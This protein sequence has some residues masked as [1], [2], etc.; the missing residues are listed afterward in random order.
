MGS[1]D[2]RA[3]RR[4]MLVAVAVA[5]AIA[6]AQAQ[7][8]TAPLPVPLPVP[9]VGGACGANAS[10]FITAG[11]ATAAQS[12]T[13]LNVNQ[14]SAN[15][16]LNWQSFNI[17]RG[18]T[19]NFRQP[20]AASIALNRIFQADASKIL[21]SLNANGRVFL[22]NQNGFVFGEGAQVNVGGLL[23]STLN[24]TP[25][26]VE[27]G[28]GRASSEGGRPAFEAFRDS[29]GNKLQS[30][31]VTIEAGAQINAAGGQVLVFAPE[32][33]N[34]GTIK[35]P[36]GQTML[37][38]GESIYLAE[39]SELRGLLVEIDTGDMASGIVTNGTA[40]NATG[41]DPA[42]LAG[43]IIAERGNITL[44]GLA[45]NQLGRVSATTSVRS[46][47]TI[48]LIAR[49]GGS[50]S[51]NAGGAPAQLL[52][53]TG[54]HLTLGAHS[55]T[56]VTLERNDA[57]RTVDVNAQPRSLVE[58]EGAAVNIL[59]AARVTATAGQIRATARTS[60]QLDPASFTN[61]SDGSRIYVAPGATLDVSGASVDL[62]V[63]RNVVRVELRGSQLANSPLQRDGALRSEPVF[64]DIRVTGTR[65]DGS[66]WRGTPLADVS[67]DISTIARTVQ[68][69]S[70][71][72]GGITLRSQGDVL[73]SAS[74]VF[75]V[76]GGRINFQDGFINTSQLLGVD[77]RV[78]DMSAADPSRQYVRVLNGVVVQHERWGVTQQFGVAPGRF[79]RGY[80]EGKDAGSVSIF[81]P[82][83]ALDGTLRAQTIAGVNQRSAP[84]AIPANELY[85]AF[86][87]RPLGGE[88]ILGNVDAQLSPATN[89]RDYVIPDVEVAAGAVLPQ[90]RSAAGGAFDP[91]VDPVMPFG[92]LRLRPEMLADGVSRVRVV[93]NGE[94]SLPAAT[95]LDLGIFGSLDV[96]AGSATI[97]GSIT[98]PAGSVRI[99]GQATAGSGDQLAPA[100]VVLAGSARIDVAGTWIN[101]N[102][103]LNPLAANAPVSINGGSISLSGTRIETAAGSVLN[104]DGGAWRRADGSLRYGNGG[105]LS[106]T[107]AG[108][109]DER[110]LTLDGTMSAFAFQRGGSLA[111]TTG[112]LCLSS[113]ACS[114]APDTA[115]RVSPEQ[116]TR[117]GF[118]NYS[119]TSTLED[120]FVEAGTHLAPRQH[121]LVFTSEV[122]GIATGTSLADFTTTELLPD[123]QRRATNLSLTAR[124]GTGF[125][126]DNQNID[127]AAELVLAAG[128]S[129]TT[130]PLAAVTLSSNARIRIDGLV[131]AP[132]GSI[133]VTLDPS[134][135]ITDFIG[136]QGIWLGE[137]A[138]L[139]ASGVPQV[140]INGLGLRTGQIMAGGQVSL[141]ANRG[142]LVMINGSVIDVSGTTGVLDLPVG[143][144]GSGRTQPETVA[145]GGGRIQLAA[146]EGIFANSTFRAASG[147]PGRIAGGTISVALSTENRGADPGGFNPLLPAGSR[148]IEISE[149]VAP[150]VVAYGS[151]PAAQLNGRALISAGALRDSGAD[152]LSFT[153][154]N[155]R[156]QSVTGS[157]VV[158]SE[159]RVVFN[160]D[161]Q[162]APRARLSFDAS[163][164]ESLG[165]TAQLS[166][167]Y[168]SLGNTDAF[169]QVL[170]SEPVA[171][172][173]VLDVQGGLVDVVGA[174]I[175]T[176]FARVNLTSRGD[177]R[178]RG[179]QGEQQASI[180]G[181]F[182]TSGAL[183]LAA[184]QVYPT[185]LSSFALEARGDGADLRGRIEIDR[186]AGDA[187]DVY[188]AGGRLALR[189]DDIVNRGTVRAPFGELT[190]DAE[191]LTLES[192]SVLSTSA[193]G[194]TI[195][196]GNTQGGFDWTYTLPNGQTLEFGADA[197]P[198]PTQRI[199]LDAEHI[200]F[201][202]GATVD[203]SGGGDLQAYEFVPGPTGTRDVL[204]NS[205]RPEQFA[206][207]PTASLAFAP[208]DAAESAFFSAL[209][210]DS[211]VIPEG[212]AG[213]PAGTYA[214]LPSR[215][216]LLP[217]AM[218]VTPV[219]GFQDLG[220]GQSMTRLDG[221]TV[222]AAYRSVAG[223][224]LRDA[225]TSG[226]A[227]SPASYARLEARYDLNRASQFFGQQIAAGTRLGFR[228]PA[229]AGRLTLTPRETLLLDGNLLTGGAGSN[230]RGA[231]VE[232]AADR[233]RIVD[234]MPTVATLGEVSVLAS[235][236][237]QL[238]PESLV[239]GGRVLAGGESPL[240]EVV[241]ST[242]SI[243]EGVRLSVPELTLAA[244][245]ALTVESGVELSTTGTTGAGEQTLRLQGDAALLRM[246]ASDSQLQLE[247]DG[248]AG[249]TGS[250]TIGEGAVVRTAGALRLD[251]SLDFALLGQLDVD[252]GSLALGAPRISLGEAPVGTGGLLLDA[253]QLASWDLDELELSSTSTL[254]F[255]SS[256][257]LA[258]DRLRLRTA[259]L[260]AV[261]EDVELSINTG[262]L[263][264]E[265]PNAAALDAPG[266]TGRLHVRAGGVELGEGTFSLGGF[267][268]AAFDVAGDI[269][270]LD[271]GGLNAGGALAINAQRLV[272]AN[273]VT[274]DFASAAHLSFAPAP[275]G[276]GFAPV[277]HDAGLGASFRM[278]GASVDLSSDILAPAGIVDV[279]AT[280]GAV[281]LS[282]G[283]DIDVSG[284]SVTFDGVT[285]AAP[286]GTVRLASRGGDVRIADGALVDVSAGGTADSRAGRIEL[287]AA[288][289]TVD[290][291]GD[292]AGAAQMAGRG[293]EFVVDANSILN[294]GALNSR[295]NAS[296]FD[297]LRDL[298]L[299]G[300]G[301]LILASGGSILAHDV[302]LAA[303]AGRID[304]GGVIDAR[305]AAGGSVN[306]FARDAVTVSG[307]IL[308]NATSDEGRGG[309]IVLGSNMDGVNL[310]ASSVLDV[311][312]GADAPDAAGDVNLRVSR[313]AL[314]RLLD[315]DATNDSTRLQGTIRGHRRLGLEGFQV[316]TDA[317]GR[318]LATDTTASPTN[319]MFND[320]TNFMNGAAQLTAALGR[321]GDESFA[322]LPGIEIR[323]AGDLTLT[324]DWNLN[325]WRFGGAP[326]VLTLRAGD[327]LRFDRSLSDGFDAITGGNAFNLTTTEDSWSY[328]LAA[329]A[330]HAAANPLGLL[331]V[332]ALAGRTGN[333]EIASGTVTS[334]TITPRM[335]RTGTGDIEI[336]VAGD[337]IFG[338]Q[339]SVLYTA[340]VAGEGIR[341][342][343]A[344][345]L[346][347]RAYPT[348]GGDISIDAR[349]DILG[350][351][352]NQ[353]V[354]DWLWR[355]GRSTDGL[356]PQATGWTVNFT[357]FAQGV[358]ALGGGD[359]SIRAGGDIDKLY[360]SIPSIGRQV[361]GTTPAESRV[362]IDGGGTLDV[363]AG[364]SI[365][366]GAYYVGLGSAYLQAGNDV[367]RGTAASPANQF[368]PIFLLGDNPFDVVAR[369]S[370]GVGG[371]SN[372][373]LLPQG[374]AQT[375]NANVTS[376]FSTYGELSRIG[377]TAI[378]GDLTYDVPESGSGD[379]GALITLL[380]GSML[381]QGNRLSQLHFG[382]HTMRFAALAGDF[383]LGSSLSL[384]PNPFGNLDVFAGN[385][386]RLGGGSE[387]IVSDADSRSLPT[388][389]TPTR[390]A[391]NFVRLF[392]ISTASGL[393]EFNAPVPVHASGDRIDDT[394]SRLVALHGDVIGTST[395]L[396]PQ[397][398]TAEPL[399]IVAGRDVVDVSFNAQN[400]ASSSVTTVQAGRDITYRVTRDPI[401][402]ALN[403]IEG[404]M[405]VEGPGRF[406]LIAGRNFDL[407]TSRG[408]T[409]Y[410]NTLNLAL[411]DGGA[412]V[413][414]S[415]GLGGRVPDF[416]AFTQTYLVTGA[417]YDRELR[418][419]LEKVT[420]ER[421]DGKPAALARFATLPL[422]LRAAFL[423][424]VMLAELRAGGRS[425]AA[426]GPGHDDYTRA[427]AA[428]STYFPGSNP[429]LDEGQ[430]NP[431]AGDI[432]LFFSR[433]YTLDGGNI[434]M[435]A[436]G[437]EIN[438]GLAAPPVAFGI[439]KPAS[440]LGV[441]VQR[442][443]NVNAV[444]FGDLQVNE[445]RVFSA[446]GGD[447]LV[448]STRG[449][450]DAGRGAKTAIS[451]PPP[452]ITFDENGQP[453]VNFPAA[454]TGSGIQTLATSAG[455]EPGD[456]DLYAP[457]GVVNAGDAGIV[458]GNLTIGATAVLGANNI[459]V[460]GV[461]VGVPVDAGGLAAGLTGVSNVAS[462]GS[463]AATA[464]V[465]QGA[466]RSDQSAPLAS[467]ALGWLEVFVEGFGDEV[468]KADDIECLAR[469]RNK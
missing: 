171:G 183:H 56:T 8:Q 274:Y 205:V 370:L 16:T 244:R 12:G 467:A 160:G 176:G 89:V 393:P 125:F 19:V 80:V 81:A 229:D 302:R 434:S 235:D 329:G 35:T 337:M 37:A 198:L 179:V 367:G 166:S 54:G 451:A 232:I 167:S 382:P 36:D 399:R 20:D 121:N 7:A 147:D 216:A 26:A 352:S 252:G 38:A 28:I 169:G 70:L 380:N 225:R 323:S 25:E 309:R 461:S 444:S 133:S 3:L 42:S 163:V 404:S 129:I 440:E 454:L 21:G 289:G 59:D 331:R 339:A 15:A 98:A 414:I 9:C 73:A 336:A 322:I 278:T 303:D 371:V 137:G 222:I 22:V 92:A 130:D 79:E 236:L 230:S 411:P 87:Q 359:V 63:D 321:S 161:L 448:W 300:A 50:A 51:P 357:R 403:Q 307:Q 290:A 111:I 377:L 330:D 238:R 6:H 332:D 463:N 203:L 142:S 417:L 150:V 452:T 294:F 315:A 308:A 459:T 2:T 362:E 272:G 333:F 154:R 202:A 190:F 356:S 301:D 231:A 187:G 33:T 433:V 170:S 86:N 181:S 287:S 126:A 47:G 209:P 284:R 255:F 23:A 280:Q 1:E 397:V 418:D 432:R 67:G 90:L 206:I 314:A 234:Q 24:M 60:S 305:G 311:S 149:T 29:E 223:T 296:G 148:R 268:N 428:L 413:S 88:L 412:D 52:A 407:Q 246:S 365:L 58:L 128:S 239:V 291:G 44:A 131:D 77:G 260:L 228:L 334:T 364:G 363:R 220:P 353:L 277:T 172:A 419:Y 373:T 180:P 441:V 114:V 221:S 422:S 138:R 385:E 43:Q 392:T 438:A 199:E 355:T 340:G 447:I 4:N 326:G 108:P 41:T 450:I 242:L 360:A 368:L 408:V 457:R 144:L 264:L 455:R 72:G 247:R 96:T 155:V 118:E 143:G 5:A 68:E 159:G 64:V 435:F 18:H 243:G 145:S 273:A 354:T 11:S 173:G 218:L 104:A 271:D 427:F 10:G 250:L 468:C 445:S 110:A 83:V 213:V 279:T 93:A 122:N 94:F 204:S 304:V 335:V 201:R 383:E 136:S 116:L 84:G 306:L 375:I 442:T 341:L 195:P 310:R 249:A 135:A 263:R 139:D 350:A 106:L 74:S 32:V 325:A 97:G 297:A 282:A 156:G 288:R 460:S 76:S 349:G 152:T 140:T 186:A 78:Y 188:S 66:T 39:S 165:G 109:P 65:V 421:I 174:S 342:G 426:A 75:D 197:R 240:L 439:N 391:A 157:E 267:A 168:I 95:G 185:T 466:G 103:L 62:P 429:D 211:I 406:E 215:Y 207:I 396:F 366:G 227:L 262:L 224:G 398:Y 376:F 153:A 420:G 387:I 431:F 189:A 374:R 251:A 237:A 233:L 61:T 124:R 320:A 369:R 193:A 48:R 351:Q 212:V 379:S 162:L 443:G 346:D 164:M 469:Q 245:D 208:F 178:L 464:V 361:G 319:G 458:A 286:G 410:G 316:Y 400:V 141:S 424:Q 226:F 394:P 358:A 292:F 313:G 423:E 261:G 115:F 210:G 449:D 395:S 13:T 219:S 132:A 102:L 381:V 317:D 257:T 436:P 69:R 405:A 388:T 327:D 259:G 40:A 318:L 175:A 158:L 117:G 453:Q 384:M 101:D 34:R 113:S 283:A 45:V 378:G 184:Q 31:P 345:S 312:A 285:V 328:R 343:G 281:T 401:S 462:G 112:A 270:A 402:G 182:T 415:A 248:A 465:D 85:R 241:S 194:L 348:R 177:L 446:D 425:A 200:D 46:N 276:I 295:L 120:L 456:V 55:S 430:Q 100:P 253:V 191:N 256:V 192:G 71:T 107:A 27:R 123:A 258:A 416:Q 293:G 266:G 214:L 299:R 127:E 269:F 91:L 30:A 409:T 82:N 389:A 146:A 99:A 53:T 437:G 254:D 275:T 344:A 105:R 298:R 265:N 151:A 347:N 14:Q 49:D 134:L 57:E 119:F 390:T 196:F 324:A 17:D 338:N 217:G 386:L 372:P